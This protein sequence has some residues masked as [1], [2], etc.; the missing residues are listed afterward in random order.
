MVLKGIFG[1]K[2]DEVTEEW[3]KLQNEVFIILSCSPNI[4]W[5]IK[6]RR[7]RWVGFVECM[8][9]GRSVFRVLVGT[10]EGKR[11]WGDNFKMVLQEVGWCDINWIDQA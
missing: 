10:T 7:M 9:E 3:R 1:H 6:L 5:V 11:T 2:R 4:V 8:G